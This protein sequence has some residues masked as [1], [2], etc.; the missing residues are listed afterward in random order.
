MATDLANSIKIIESN[1]DPNDNRKPIICLLGW[2]GCNDRYLAKY[3]QIYED[4]GYAT[5]R[6]TSPINK[7]RSLQCYEQYGT[8]VFDRLASIDNISERKLIF[9]V[10]S[11]NGAS[12]YLKVYESYQK[13]NATGF[14]WRDEAIIFDSCPADVKPMQGATAISFALCPPKKYGGMA[15]QIT[16]LF[17]AAGFAG[18]RALVHIKSWLIHEAYENNFAYYRLI[19]MSCLPKRQLYLYSDLDDI[20]SAHSIESFIEVQKNNTNNV[21]V[22]SLNFQNSE[23]CQHYRTHPELYTKK[24]L[25]FLEVSQ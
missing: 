19:S 14:R 24:C 8:K 16:K 6:T 22:N 1:F 5:I 12:T 13:E 15:S 2:A 4:A 11:M 17:L 3:S 25:D 10:F 7:I 18:H 21:S 20:C 23:H 9:H